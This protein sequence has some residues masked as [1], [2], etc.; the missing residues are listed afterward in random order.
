MHFSAD[1][2]GCGSRNRVIAPAM[3]PCCWRRRRRPVRAI[4]WS[5][6]APASAPAGL[7][8]ARRVRRNR[9]RSGRDRRGARGA[10]ARQRCLE[11]DCRRCRRAGCDI[12]RRRLCRRRSVPRQR[13]CRADEPAVQRFRRGTAPRPTRRARSRMSRR[14]RRWKTGFMPARRILKSGGVLTLIWRA[15]GLAEVLAALDRG[16]GSLD[17]LP[18]HGDAATPAIRVLVRAR[19][20]RQGADAHPCRADAQ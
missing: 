1:D 18:V 8:L 2:C 11:C 12:G 19:Q 15:D 4:A 6:S 7:A 9:T 17:I 5:I 3:T 14:R 13:R 10:C 20:G 16:F